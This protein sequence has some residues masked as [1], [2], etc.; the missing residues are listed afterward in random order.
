MGKILKDEIWCPCPFC[1]HG[2]QGVCTS[3]LPFTIQSFFQQ[4]GASLTSHILVKSKRDLS[5]WAVFNTS[6][7]WFMIF[8]LATICSYNSTEK[9]NLRMVLILETII[10][11][12]QAYDCS[13][14]TWWLASTYDSCSVLQPCNSFANLPAGFQQTKP[15]KKPADDHNLQSCDVLFNNHSKKVVTLDVIMWSFT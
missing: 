4:S 11:S 3:V 8:A 9:S 2:G 14:G 5:Y 12:L 15:M 7:L 10:A 13:L 6:S 1:F